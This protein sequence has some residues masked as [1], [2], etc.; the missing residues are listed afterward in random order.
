MKKVVETAVALVGGA[1]G[2]LAAVTAASAISDHFAEKKTIEDV[3]DEDVAGI[4][5][6]DVQKANETIFKGTEF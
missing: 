4:T 6:E 5:D 1:I 2:G 3:S